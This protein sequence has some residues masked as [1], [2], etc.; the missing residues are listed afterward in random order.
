MQLQSPLLFLSIC[1]LVEVKHNTQYIT[2]RAVF[3][4]WD[5]C[6]SRH[7]VVFDKSSGLDMG[8]VGFKLA[9]EGGAGL[10][11]VS[12]KIKQRY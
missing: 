5:V 7:G 4:L 11:H 1:G 8:Q 6:V 3:F 9:S 12:C 2:V 10:Q